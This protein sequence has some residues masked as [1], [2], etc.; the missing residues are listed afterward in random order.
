[1]KMSFG[2]IFSVILI[3]IFIAFAFY[4]IKTLIDGN[5]KNLIMLFINDLRHDIDSAWK[6]TQSSQ[7]IIYNLPKKIEYVCFVDYNS[8]EKGANRGFYRELERFYYGSENLI[9]YPGGS[10]EELSSVEIEDINIEK[11]TESEN[12]FCIENIDG[13]VK[14]TIKKNFGE[15]LVLIER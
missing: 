13:R 4:V 9:F 11:I 12:P 2:M 1:M 7:E 15:E 8:R 3:I 6:G 5:E 10:F 14:M